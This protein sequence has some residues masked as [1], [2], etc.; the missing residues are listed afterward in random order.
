MVVFPDLR[1]DFPHDIRQ[2]QPGRANIGPRRQHGITERLRTVIYMLVQ[3]GDRFVG[4][5]FPVNSWADIYQVRKRY[6]IQPPILL[7]NDLV[8]HRRRLVRPCKEFYFISAYR[9]FSGR[10]RRSSR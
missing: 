8:V 10:A 9:V 7:V 3:D 2:I 5:Q 6:T 4:R 1:A